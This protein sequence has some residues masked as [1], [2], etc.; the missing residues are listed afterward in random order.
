MYKRQVGKHTTCIEV[1][2]SIEHE[3]QTP[4]SRFCLSLDR[5]IN[6]LIFFSQKVT[7][8]AN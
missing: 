2:I 6:S 4:C 1:V 5:L 8:E 3:D 7:K